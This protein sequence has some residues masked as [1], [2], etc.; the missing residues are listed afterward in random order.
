MLMVEAANLEL[1]KDRVLD[2]AMQTLVAAMQALAP[3]AAPAEERRDWAGLPIELLV[4]IAETHI[5][6]S[7]AGWAARCKELNPNWTEEEIQDE[8]TERKLE[9]NCLFVF[10]MVC[11]GWRRAQGRGTTR[12]GL[13]SW[14]PASA[15]W[16]GSRLGW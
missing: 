2:P 6:Q 5:A 10:A 12:R 4:K 13:S 3:G 16:A 9:G 11:K 8:M 7:E 14:D 1:D 15:S